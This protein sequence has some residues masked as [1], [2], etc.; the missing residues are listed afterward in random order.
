M[1]ED[2]FEDKS[3][4]ATPKKRRD[5]RKKGEVAK[6]RELPS[7]AVLLAGMMTFVLFGAFMYDRI[8]D[9]MVTA[10]SLPVHN[11]LSVTELIRF[12]REMIQQFFWI[13]TPLAGMI[14]LAAVVSNILQVGF[15]INAESLKPKFSKINPMKGLGRL[16][17]KQSVMEL[18]KSIFKLTIVGGVGYITIQG[19]MDNLHT[20]GYLPHEEIIVYLFAATFK[21]FVRCALAMIVIVAIDYAFQKWQFETKLKMSKKEVKDEHKESEGDPMIK[22]RIRSIQMQMARNR[23]MQSV[24]DADV[25][26]TNPTHYAIALKYDDRTMGAPKVVAKGK[27]EIALKIKEIAGAHQILMVENRSLAQTLYQMVE[28]GHEVPQ[29]LYQ[30]VAEVLAYVYKQKRR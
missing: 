16:F 5:A 23:M 17:S 6:S 12:S 18:L 20:L 25:V 9:M 2:S 10:F 24:P 28:I 11:T 4:Q 14:V 27:G 13:M 3:E 26:V 8:Q 1:A 7:V 30:A 15:M 21:L 29:L 22:S 19:E